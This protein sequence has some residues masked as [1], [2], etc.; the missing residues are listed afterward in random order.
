MTYVCIK[1]SDTRVLAVVELRGVLSFLEIPPMAV[2]RRKTGSGRMGG[3]W[4]PPLLLGVPAVFAFAVDC[5]RRRQ[6]CILSPGEAPRGGAIVPATEESFTAAHVW[7]TGLHAHLCTHVAV[8][9]TDAGRRRE[10]EGNRG[11][12]SAAAGPWDAVLLLNLAHRV[13]LRGQPYHPQRAR[14]REICSSRRLRSVAA[15]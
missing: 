9:P 4:Q 15:P 12:G 3:R 14:A 10:E 1:P 11:S 2:C 13:P 8:Q 6:D 5:S 7:D